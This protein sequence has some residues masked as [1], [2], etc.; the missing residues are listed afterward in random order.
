KGLVEAM[1]VGNRW[2]D[3][4]TDEFKTGRTGNEILAAAHEATD[5]ARLKDSIY[6]HPLGI[7]GHAPGPTIGMWDNQGPTPVRGDWPLYPMTGYAIEGNVTVE[8]PEFDNQPIQMKLEQSAYFDGNEV[9]YLADR[10]TEWHL[11]R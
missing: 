5:K 7:Y 2:Q 9:I 6:T 4:L 1:A 3:L 8:I 10:Q 11:V